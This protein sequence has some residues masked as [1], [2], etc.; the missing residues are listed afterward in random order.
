MVSEVKECSKANGKDLIRFS[1]IFSNCLF[2]N[3][4]SL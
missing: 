4:P 3:M 2:Y 1:I